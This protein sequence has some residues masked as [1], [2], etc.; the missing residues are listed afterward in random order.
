M[1]Y[2]LMISPKFLKKW[3]FLLFT[4]DLKMFNRVSSINDYLILQDELNVLSDWC[5]KWFMRIIKP[6]Y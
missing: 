5:L 4:D 2:L 3:H 6:E 1:L